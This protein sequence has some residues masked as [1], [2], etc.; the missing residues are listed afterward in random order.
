MGF[1]LS[2]CSYTKHLLIVNKCFHL[3]TSCWMSAVVFS[4]LIFKIQTTSKLV[5]SLEITYM[6][7]VY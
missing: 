1:Q 4:D 6:Y 2:T 7:M 3:Y 5:G